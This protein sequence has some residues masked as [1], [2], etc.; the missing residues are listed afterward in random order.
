M[1]NEDDK[2]YPQIYLEECEYK[3]KKAK[4]KTRLIR[5]GNDSDESNDEPIE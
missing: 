2:Y 5:N 1:K 4:K 3:G